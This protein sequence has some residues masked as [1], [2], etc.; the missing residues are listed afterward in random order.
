[1]LEV[2]ALEVARGETWVLVGPNGAGKTSLL[3]VLGL[4]ERPAAGQFLLF[5]EEVRKASL[6]L[7]RR[8][9]TIFQE[10]LLLDESALANVTLPLSLRGHVRAK[11]ESDARAA[12]ALFGAEHL[13]DRRAR[14]L[15][16]GEARRIALAR[17]FAPR[18]DLLLLDEPFAALD[19]PSREALAIDLKQAIRATG[20]TC[21]VVTHDRAE[22][23]SLSDHT[24][25][26][27]GGQLVQSGLTEEVFRSPANEAVARFIGVENLI[28][29]RIVERRED[30]LRLDASGVGL[31]GMPSATKGDTALACIRA[32]DVL[33]ATGKIESLSARN[34]LACT[35]V[36]IEPA[37]AGVY[38]RL[39]APFPLVALLTRAAVEEL[40]L[41]PGRAVTAC[42]KSNAVHLA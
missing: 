14:K 37:A 2:G 29:V 7:R 16:G 36:A 5:G 40:G 41:A 3:R 20:T 13:A 12:L 9:L 31:T 28:Q 1:V 39:A 21:V 30:S 42:F 26:I 24:G 6:A 11:A 8:V 15:S 32:Q 22:A 25:V 35:V 17:G 34:C 23:L 27:L 4:L 18:P 19:P 33:V 38:V 10:T